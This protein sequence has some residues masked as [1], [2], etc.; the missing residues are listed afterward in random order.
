MGPEDVFKKTRQAKQPVTE[1]QLDSIP[2]INT[3]TKVKVV[4]DKITSFQEFATFWQRQFI[5]N[6]DAISVCCF[7]AGLIY[8]YAVNECTGD[9]NVPWYAY[10]LGGVA[11]FLFW[12]LVI[13]E[14]SLKLVVIIKF[15][16]AFLFG[17]V[18]LMFAVAL[19]SHYFGYFTFNVCR[20]PFGGNEVMW[21]SLGAMG[22][23]LYAELSRS[24]K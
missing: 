10:I 6:E 1:P 20:Y 16:T 19:D 8:S 15:L 17:H 14:S 22:G 2:F 21:T 7:G 5:Q 12:L 9:V 24:R 4:E 13:R 18:F 11:A 3:G 23:F